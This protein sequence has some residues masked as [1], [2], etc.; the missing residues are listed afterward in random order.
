MRLLTHLAKHARIKGLI[1][2]LRNKSIRHRDHHEGSDT[3]TFIH[4]E[5][6]KWWNEVQDSIDLDSTMDMLEQEE[7]PN[8]LTKIHDAHLVL[9]NIS[10]QELLISLNRPLLATNGTSHA[11]SAALQ[12]CISASQKIISTLRKSMVRRND[13]VSDRS[14]EVMPLLIW[15]SLTWAIWMS[16]F[17]LIYASLE[18]QYPL[19]S[20]ARYAYALLLRITLSE[21][22]PVIE[23]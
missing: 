13:A 17:V 23:V 18:S 20:C 22:L 15:P 10:K 1:L 21:P 12:N 8:E 7:T 9:L 6:S 3:A 4:A 19:K 14:S 2:E 5:L 16:C 11:Y